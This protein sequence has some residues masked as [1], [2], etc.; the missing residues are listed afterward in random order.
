MQTG[1]VLNF[2]PIRRFGFIAPDD[3]SAA[4][5]VHDSA[6]GRAGLHNVME[7]GLRV[8][9]TTSIDRRGTGLEALNLKLIDE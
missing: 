4:V 3:G 1:T 2:D 9:F 8:A 5:Y 7:K 6:V